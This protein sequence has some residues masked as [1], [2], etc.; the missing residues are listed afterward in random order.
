MSPR[1]PWVSVGGFTGWNRWLL[2]HLLRMELQLLF[3]AFLG[4]I[5]G[6]RAP[7]PSETEPSGDLLSAKLPSLLLSWGH[8]PCPRALTPPAPPIAACDSL[9]EGDPELF[10]LDSRTVQ[11]FI[12]HWRI[13]ILQ[14]CVSAI[15]QHKSAVGIHMSPPSSL[16]SFPSPTPYHPSRLSQSTSLNSLSDTANSPAYP[17]HIW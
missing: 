6:A 8:H 1:F 12:F 7:F 4:I 9:P 2:L 14:Y 3:Q 10:L 5:H 17:F 11:F 15:H 16:P 13:I